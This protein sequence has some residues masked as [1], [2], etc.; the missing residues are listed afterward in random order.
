MAPRGFCPL[1]HGIYQANAGGRIQNNIVYNVTFAGIHLWH[2]GTAA[3]IANNLVWGAEVGILVGGD[4]VAADHDIVSNNIVR[5][6]KVGIEELGD[7]FG[8][9]N[10]YLNNL[11][12]R[13]GTDFVMV[14][15]KPA[16]TVSANPRMIDFRRTGRGDYHLSAGSPAVDAGANEGAPEEDIDGVRRPQQGAID[17]GPYEYLAGGAAASTR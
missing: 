15:G 14:R 12:Y 8:A 1:I 10:S 11:V 6:N 4:S 13:N 2:S 9:N 7:H 17:I 16:H 5:N 3:T